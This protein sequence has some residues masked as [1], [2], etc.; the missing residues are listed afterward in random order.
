MYAQEGKNV[1]YVFVDLGKVVWLDLPL[2][3]VLAFAR[4]KTS[5][6]LKVL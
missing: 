5:S 6:S 1:L 3:A 4:S 2:F